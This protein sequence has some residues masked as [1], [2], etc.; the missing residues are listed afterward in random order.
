MILNTTYHERLN[1]LNLHQKIYLR[2]LL[3]VV[4]T[5]A[6]IGLLYLGGPLALE[7]MTPFILASPVAMEIVKVCLYWKRRVPAPRS[8]IV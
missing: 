1:T 2:V 7:I 5:L 3:D 8:S 6:A 4:L